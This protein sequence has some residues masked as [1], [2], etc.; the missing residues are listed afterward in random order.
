[1]PTEGMSF[2][3]IVESVFNKCGKDEVRLFAG[4][5]RRIWLR[6]NDYVH[7]G[8]FTHPTALLQGAL[9]S[10][11]EFSEI[12]KLEGPRPSLLA[13]TVSRCWTA[14]CPRWLKVNWDASFQ[15]SSGRMGFG[16]VVRDEQGT[17][18]AAISKTMVGRL[19]PS[20]AEGRALLVAIGLCKEMGFRDIQFEGDAQ[21]VINAVN[22]AE[23]DWSRIGLMVTD[24]KRELETLSQ[25]RMQ[26]VPRGSNGVAHILSKEATT[27]FLNKCWINEVPD[28]IKDLVLLESRA[29]SFDT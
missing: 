5:A 29:V 25:W 3:Q 12:T 11:E 20:V 13:V 21:V 8:L 2:R 7:G 17:V 26:F 16:A 14:P 28:C 18:K 24:I 1:M 4:T 6:R 15:L 19:D 9:H 23:T 22:S 27:S 10:M